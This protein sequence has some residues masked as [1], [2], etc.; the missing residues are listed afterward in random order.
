MKRHFIL[1]TILITT[2]SACFQQENT[3]AVPA[4]APTITAPTQLTIAAFNE[5][6]PADIYQQY[7]W[8]NRR[9]QAQL[10]HAN[11]AQANQ[12]YDAYR[13][14]TDAV[15]Q[16]INDQELPFLENYADDQYWLNDETASEP[17]P[18]PALVQ[19][20]QQLAQ[21]GLRYVD[22]GEGMAEIAPV[23]N[24]ETQL[25]GGKVSPDY[26]AYIQQQDH[27]NN[28]LADSDAAIVISWT[29]LAARVAFWEKFVQDHPQS[30]FAS[31]AQQRLMWYAN[32]FLFGLDNTPVEDGS[33]FPKGEA[34]DE[35]KRI[36]DEINHAWNV[37][38]RQYP[39]SRITPLI[40][41]ARQI[42]TLSADERINA[43][44]QLRGQQI[45]LLAASAPA[46]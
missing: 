39:Q 40:A 45:G 30:P 33:Q 29:E 28:Q 35:A 43:M 37:F 31:D 3:P 14:E 34:Q 2:L 18:S 32:A 6:K 10:A 12:L 36:F 38:E 44:Q 5:A 24:T 15:L 23:A 16:A 41:Q 4:S 46:P 20:H 27:E 25:F 22:I 8:L 11:V 1:S 19:K 7:A 9:A 42:A 13:V 21:F 26:Q 17:K